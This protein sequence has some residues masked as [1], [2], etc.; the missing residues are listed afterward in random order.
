MPIIA[1]P[2]GKLNK[3]LGVLTWY[4]DNDKSILESMLN[5]KTMPK[6]INNDSTQYMEVL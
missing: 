2:V 6:R 1:I 5:G 4:V 3:P